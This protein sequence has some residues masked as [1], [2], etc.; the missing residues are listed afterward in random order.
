[1]DIHDFFNID[2]EYV[3]KLA[4]DVLKAYPFIKKLYAL[5]NS[6]H[7]TNLKIYATYNCGISNNGIN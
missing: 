1:M 3:N 6:N 5:Y 2:I 7:L 4:D